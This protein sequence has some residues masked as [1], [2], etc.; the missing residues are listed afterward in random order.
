MDCMKC[1]WQP[2]VHLRQQSELRAAP[3][4]NPYW[5]QVRAPQQSQSEMHVEAAAVLAEYFEIRS[6]K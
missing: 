6:A 3:E 1:D 4:Q 2:T 5:L